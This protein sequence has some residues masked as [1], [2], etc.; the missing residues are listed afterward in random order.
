MLDVLIK[1]IGSLVTAEGNTPLSGKNQGNVRFYENAAIGIKDGIIEYV[2][3]NKKLK[4]KKTINAHGLL[5]TSGLID[6]HTHF[7]FGGSREDE[8]YNIVTGNMSYLDIIK[9]GY[10]IL[11]TVKDTRNKTENFL[12]KKTLPVLDN[13]LKYG[14]TTLEGK[15]GYGLTLKDEIKILKV[16][17]KLNDNHQIDI[18]ATF[19]GGHVVPDEYKNDRDGYIELI[20][21]D[22]IPEISKLKLA[23]FC[24]VF[25]DTGG[26][27]MEETHK[28]LNSAQ[29]YNMGLKVHSDQLETSGGSYLAA[30]FKA[31]SAEHLIM[32]DDR[33]INLIGKSGVVAVLLPNTSFYL[34]MPYARARYMIE[35]DVPIA[36][37]SDYNPGSSPSYNIQFIM[38]LSYILYKL[39]P[40]EILN[41]VTINAACAINRG[42]EI[43]TIEVG[44]KA[45]II[46]WNAYNLNFLVYTLDN[47]LCNMV[48]KSGNIVYQND[49]L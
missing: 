7:V 47:N 39:K 9:S 1:N 26:F 24:N 2:G 49:I 12:Y 14:T 21:N 4:A 25:C 38:K 11:S 13:M 17:K 35:M 6:C 33:A 34:S 32:S 40:E 16:M 43:G 46:I 20:C 22:M 27:D 29:E 28:I 48:L 36:I 37:A 5:V 23:E 3:D 18:V 44:K 10:G 42:D 41:S 31:V 8:M 45:D 30:R 19:M 15:S